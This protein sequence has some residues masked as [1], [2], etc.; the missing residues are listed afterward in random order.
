MPVVKLT[1][2][3][4]ARGIQ[5]SGL[6]NFKSLRLIPSISV[7]CLLGNDLIMSRMCGG[8]M[9]PRLNSGGGSSVGWKYDSGV[10]LVGGTL[11]EILWPAVTKKELN[12]LAMSEG[13][14]IVLP[15][16]SI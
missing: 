11:S 1:S 15:S 16:T 8:L 9:L 6:T 2:K 10:L 4:W 13:E 3:I 12:S 5:I 7:L 14:L